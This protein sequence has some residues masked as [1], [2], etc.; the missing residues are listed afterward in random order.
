MNEKAAFAERLVAAMKRANLEPR[1]SVLEKE[2]NSH[3]WGRPVTYQAVA[4]WL[5][6]QAMPTQDKLEVLARVLAIEPQ[7]LRYG[8]GTVRKVRER[9][10]LWADGI[11]PAERE[12]IEAFLAL[13]TTQRK[14]V[15]EVILAF[16]QAYAQ[17]GQ[18]P[19]APARKD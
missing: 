9:Q 12:L 13:P 3:F 7:I 18:T 5:K 15:R 10:Q 1:P 14:V 11:T 2:F 4:R 6:G 17:T 16:V 19:D 8:E